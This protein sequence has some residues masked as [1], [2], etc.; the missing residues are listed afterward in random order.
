[1]S[2]AQYST[3]Q[4]NIVHGKKVNIVLYIIIILLKNK[5]KTTAINSSKLC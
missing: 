5:I 4:Y 2:I 3:I 1:M